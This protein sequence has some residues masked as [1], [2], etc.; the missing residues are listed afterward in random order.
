MALVSIIRHLQKLLLAKLS[1]KN[2]S[3]EF[4]IY[5]KLPVLILNYSE[6]YFEKY[7]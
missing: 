7:S 3:D 2:I 6:I 4:F 1:K 5:V